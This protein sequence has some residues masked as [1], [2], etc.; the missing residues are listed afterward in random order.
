MKCSVQQLDELDLFEMPK[1]LEMYH[2]ESKV[3]IPLNIPNL[4]KH[5][6]IAHHSPSSIILG[7]FSDNVLVGFIWGYMEESM[8]SGEIHSREVA[9]Y[10]NPDFRGR[11]LANRL[12]SHLEKWS[13][14]SGAVSIN[15]GANSGINDN[16][17]AVRLYSHLGYTK[18]GVSLTK[19]IGE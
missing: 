4:M 18:V 15:V 3:E 19:R 12:I 8:W 7:A 1:L 17:P 13:I 10:I 5:M 2:T 9:L 11:T 14:E 6:F 16:A